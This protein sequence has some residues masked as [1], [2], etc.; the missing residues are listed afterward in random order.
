MTANTKYGFYLA[1]GSYIEYDLL[2]DSSLVDIVDKLALAYLEAGNDS[3]PFEVWMQPKYVSLLNRELSQ[4]LTII[5]GYLN[6]PA[7]PQFLRIETL[8][9]PVIILV[10]EQLSIPVFI[11]S[12]EELEDNSF[13]VQMDKILAPQS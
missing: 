10:S 9:G 12:E 6:E 7:Y 13:C 3:Y 1:N 2:P 11:G 8:G 4:S 5:T